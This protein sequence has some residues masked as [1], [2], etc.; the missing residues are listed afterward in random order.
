MATQTYYDVLGVDP[1]ADLAQIKRAYR[2]LARRYH[3]D[4]NPDE[5]AVEVFQ[6][7]T[8]IY[9]VLLDPVE[10]DRYNRLINLPGISD[11]LP[12][13]DAE[14]AGGDTALE[15]YQ[16]GLA[17]AQKGYYR[18]AVVIFSK[19]LNLDSSYIDAYAQRGFAYYSLQN[20]PA[21]LADYGAALQLDAHIAPVHFYRGLARFDLGDTEAATRDFTTALELDAGYAK[22]YYRRGL[23]YADLGDRR[24]ASTDLRQAVKSFTNQGDMT[25][26][27]QA[28]AALK[29]VE[30]WFALRVFR[31][32]P[33]LPLR[34]AGL[35]MR[36]CA[37][38]I[39]GLLPAFV[40]LGHTR[41]I[42][43]GLLFGTL[44][45][46]C[47]AFKMGSPTALPS[48]YSLLAGLLPLVSMT[49][50]KRVGRSLLDGYSSLA[51]DIFTAG[52]ALLPLSGAVLASGLPFSAAVSLMAI[53]TSYAVLILYSSCSQIA[54]LPEAKASALT[55]L[56]LTA[57]LLP[58]LGLLGI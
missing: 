17:Q 25:R 15:L 7:L 23:A 41:A 28:K 4:V 22:A 14:N 35:V 53:A 56:L 44:F 21:A 37:N 50:T 38:P 36:R 24:A 51:G 32:N 27:R 33:L 49:V 40:R 16:R 31:M 55:A 26:A 20:Y 52:V 1:S 30:G 42:A 48:L 13:E 54:N 9:Q 12:V 45:A 19:A 10:R 43:V 58:I 46:L 57:A 18:A 2:R 29:Q 8:D 34:D 6:R 3:P 5:N 39:S 11:R 47:L